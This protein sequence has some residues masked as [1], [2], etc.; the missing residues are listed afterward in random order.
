[1]GGPTWGPDADGYEVSSFYEGRLTSFP[2]LRIKPGTKVPMDRGWS[3]LNRKPADPAP[4]RKKL[5][6]YR[7]SLAAVTGAG[8]AVLDVDLDVAGAAESY[9]EL[10]GRCFELA[11]AE[12]DWAPTVRTPSGG[13]HKYFTVNDPLRSGPIRGFVG[14]DFKCEGG[15]VL[16]PPSDGYDWEGE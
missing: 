16:V 8:Y 1:M 10:A 2:L 12:V 14:I 9:A 3:S 5:I 11:D 7:G 6:G 4:W 15:F 13:V